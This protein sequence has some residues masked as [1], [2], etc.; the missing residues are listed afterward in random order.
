MCRKP[1]SKQG[2][3]E[4]AEYLRIVL[5]TLRD[6]KLF[7]KFRKSE[8]LLRKVRFLGHIVSAKG[9]RVD[10]SKILAIVDWKSPRNA[11]EVRSF[12]GLARYYRRFVKGF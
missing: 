12:L 10:P 7:A 8:F 4:Y 5:Q 1:R 9:I 11:S 6:K 3:I 2:E